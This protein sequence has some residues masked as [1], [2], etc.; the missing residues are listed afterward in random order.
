MY[1]YVAVR[2]AVDKECL[3]NS[4][5]SEDFFAT[6][7]MGDMLFFDDLEQVELYIA[8]YN[9]KGLPIKIKFK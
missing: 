3:K 4:V 2:N 6:D 5:Y 1:K 8:E 9:I 7:A